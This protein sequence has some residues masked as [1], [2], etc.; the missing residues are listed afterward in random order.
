[1]YKMLIESDTATW[2]LASNSTTWTLTCN[3][4]RVTSWTLKGGKCPTLL[5]VF[6]AQRLYEQWD[7]Y[8][9]FDPYVDWVPFRTYR[10]TL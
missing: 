8:C 3:G 4:D 7:N 2:I 5:A 6:A 1:M 10:D 9:G